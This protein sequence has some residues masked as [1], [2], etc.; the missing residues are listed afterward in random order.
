M[1]EL[2]AIICPEAKE[3]ERRVALKN[4]PIAP[5]KDDRIW[6]DGEEFEVVRREFRTNCGDAD[7]SKGEAASVV[8]KKV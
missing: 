7:G 8:L 4:F 6:I 5:E 3:I 1:I 2:L